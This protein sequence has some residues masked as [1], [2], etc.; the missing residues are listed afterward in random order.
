MY[1]SK[2]VVLNCAGLGSRLGLGK[3]K[4]L[5]NLEGKP[6]IHWQ[7]DMLKN[8]QDVRIVVGFEAQEVINT[9]LAIRKDVLFVFNHNYSSTKTGASLALGALHS[10]NFIVS[11]DGD[12]LVHPEDFNYFLSFE[13]EC[14]AYTEINTEEPCYIQLENKNNKQYITRFNPLKKSNYEWNGLAQ[15]HA[16][17]IK[18]TNAH[19][20]EMLIPFLPLRAIRIRTQEIDTLSDYEKAVYWLRKTYLENTEEK[21]VEQGKNCEILGRTF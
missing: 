2:T 15:I 5:I 18:A 8:I 21:Y 9:V 14:L 13:E 4:A 1:F 3:T 17:K 12:L 7:L 19:V 11:L 10:N 16:S 20:Y 6:L